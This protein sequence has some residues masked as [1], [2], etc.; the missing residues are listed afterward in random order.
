MKKQVYFIVFLCLSISLQAQNQSDEEAI[1]RFLARAKTAY[2]IGEYQDALTEYQ[3]VQQMIPDYPDIYKVLGDVYEKLGTDEDLKL[4]IEN[5]SHYLKLTPNLQDKDVIIE[6]ISS[7]EY[8]YEKQ[9]KQTQILDDLSGIWI[10]ELR[11]QTLEDQN[12]NSQTII[13]MPDGKSKNKNRS[14][15][16]MPIS[17]VFKITEIGHEGKF[18]I[19]ILP[20]SGFYKE[21]IVQK[22]ANIVPDKKNSIIFTFADAQ[23]YTP[24]QSK[25]DWMRLGVNLLS[26]NN[27]LSRQVST[28]FINSFQEKDL[29]SNTQTAYYF[30]L[31]Y[32]DGKLKGFCNIVQQKADTKT[33]QYTYDDYFEISLQ[34]DDEYYNRLKSEMEIGRWTVTDMSG[35]NLTDFDVTK[36]LN[37]HPDL[38]KKYNSGKTISAVGGVFTGFGLGGLIGLTFATQEY[39]TYC[40][41]GGVGFT[42]IGIPLAIS[43]VKKQKNVM[44]EFNNRINSEQNTLSLQFGITSSGGFGLTYNF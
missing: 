23:A 8:L 33:N 28:I 25:Y 4:A 20:E 29:P 6:K 19:E 26:G 39:K 13:S 5:Y 30:D 32:V 40:L 16:K 10:S 35:R 24:S 15:S 44:R 1:K 22:V 42:M 2:S 9:L 18:R 43:G 11:M 14:E 37:A 27:D 34:K 17:F 12:T 38:Y 36:R 7:L 3:K 41:I 21:S 31:K